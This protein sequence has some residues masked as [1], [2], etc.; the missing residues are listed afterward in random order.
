LENQ[1]YIQLLKDAFQFLFEKYNFTVAQHV[2]VDPFWNAQTYLKSDGLLLQVIND[3]CLISLDLK[4]FDTKKPL[5]KQFNDFY[6]LRLIL[7]LLGVPELKDL[8][9][10]YEKVLTEIFCEDS[11]WCNMIEK[12]RGVVQMHLIAEILEKYYEQIL[13]IFSEE[14][15]IETTK[16]LTH[17]K[18]EL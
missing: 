1:T 18:K 15:L 12:E 14:N 2:A 11:E 4:P 7:T 3:W 13:D 17:L 9:N 8:E 10:M 16:K 6:D 5:K